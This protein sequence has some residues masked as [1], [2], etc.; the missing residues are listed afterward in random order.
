MYSENTFEFVLPAEELIF[1]VARV[2]EVGATA[3]P[4]EFASP[5]LIVALE[6][7]GASSGLSLLLRREDN[8]V[9]LGHGDFL[10]GLEEFKQGALVDGETKDAGE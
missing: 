5:S 10:Q 1:G 7:Q 3:G 4:L 2:G 9:A 6:S 8:E